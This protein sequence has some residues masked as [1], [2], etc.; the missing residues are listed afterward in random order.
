MKKYKFKFNNLTLILM[1]DGILVAIGCIIVNA[2]R[3]ISKINGDYTLTIYEYISFPLIFLL[4]V[5][6][7][8]IIVFAFFNSYYKIDENKVVLKFGIIKNVIDLK[9]VTEIKL[10][11]KKNKLELIFKDESYFVIATNPD[12]FESFVDEIKQ[13]QPKI[14][15]VQISEEENTK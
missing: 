14:A 13:K 6:F 10:L 12:W 4:A 8:V 15:F 3:L 11:T 7:I 9:E 5:G 1:L 2:L